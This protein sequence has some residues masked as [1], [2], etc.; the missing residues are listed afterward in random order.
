MLNETE[1]GLL[2]AA[3]RPALV[4]LDEEELLALHDRIRRARNKYSTL[5]RRRASARVARDQSRGRAHETNAR[6]V[7][8]AEAFEDAL[9][10]VSQALA[11]AARASAGEL[12]RERIAAATRLRRDTVDVAPRRTTRA[13]SD[14][15]AGAGAKAQRRTPA[16]KR[17][18]ASAR[19]A[20]RRHQAKRAHR[21]AS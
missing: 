4:D 16:A 1:K 12:K 21:S 18:S 5:Y 17:A 8:K 7:V 19:A 6:T 15:R 13:G 14:V 11:R 9:A 3:E 2:R 10:R 20:T